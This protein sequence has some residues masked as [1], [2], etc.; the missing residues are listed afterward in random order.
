MRHTLAIAK[1]KIRQGLQTV[2]CL[3]HRGQFTEGQ[4]AGN[5]GESG[6]ATQQRLLDRPHFRPTQHHHRSPRD[7]PTAFESDVNA[8]YKAQRAEFV[9]L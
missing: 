9:A 1:N 3:K 5:I 8:G 2:D 7:R 6:F 4:Q